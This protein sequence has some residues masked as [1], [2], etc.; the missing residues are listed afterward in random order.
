[1][2]GRLSIQ[3]ATYGHASVLA[4]LHAECFGKECWNLAQIEG[5]LGLPTTHGWIAHNGETP[6]AFIL[7][8]VLPGQAEI[9]TFG[10]HPSVQRQNI[11]S[12]LLRHAM[13]VLRKDGNTRIFLEVAA[14]NYAARKLYETVGFTVTGTR[15]N[16]YKRG[17]VTV[18]AVVY[19]C[20]GKTN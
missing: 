12:A 3:P 16:Y 18:D 15:T 17:A 1:M 2:I 8:Q 7:F 4:A 11:G 14:D 5:S 9:L 20:T 10:V 19:A 13:N 6:I